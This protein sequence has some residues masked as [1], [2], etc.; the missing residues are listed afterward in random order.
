MAIHPWLTSDH[1]PGDPVPTE[2]ILHCGPSAH[3]RVARQVTFE[4]S[5]RNNSSISL[6]FDLTF[7]QLLVRNNPPIPTGQRSLVTGRH[8][9][10]RGTPFIL[11]HPGFLFPVH[12]L[13]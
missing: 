1:P 11:N 13:R 7:I 8:P 9:S 12:I 5:T 4:D 6:V 3:D 2:P 10:S